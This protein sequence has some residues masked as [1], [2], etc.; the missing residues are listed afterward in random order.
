MEVG[1]LKW[2]KEFHPE[3]LRCLMGRPARLFSF[4]LAV[5]T[6]MLLVLLGGASV[7]RAQD[8]PG[9]WSKPVMISEEIKSW[10]P[11]LATDLAGGVHV[12]WATERAALEKGVG[13]YDTV[14]YCQPTVAG[15]SQSIE[16]A[17]LA[18]GGGSYSTRPAAVVDSQG[19]IHM[20]WHGPN[21][22]Y[23]TSV[24]VM[25]SS[26]ARNW[27]P[28]RR[29]SGSGL[30][31]YVDV[32]QDHQG[33][34]HVVWSESILENKSEDCP[35][36]SDI[37]YR[38]SNDRG[39]TWSAPVD[40]SNTVLGSQKPQIAIG[41][42][43]AVYVA[44]EEGRDLLVGADKASSSMLVASLD[45]G[46]TWEKP[47]TFIF[48]GD[49]PQSIAAGIDGQGK[50]IVVWRQIAGRGIFYQS[51][52]DHG[53]SWSA[54]E[55]IP[56]VSTRSLYNGLD[57]YH[58][59]VDSAGHLHL[60]L[61]GTDPRAV[62]ASAD[63]PNDTMLNSVYHLEWDGVHWSQPTPIF[64][65]R[66]D[67]PEWPRIA[68]V[69]GNQLHVVWFVRD[70]AHVW[71]S[72]KGEYRVW[73]A[74]GSSSAPVETPVAWPAA[75][76]TPESELVKVASLAPVPPPTLDPGL[77]EVS[78]PPGATDSIYTETDDLILLVKSL[79]PAMLVITLAVVVARIRRRG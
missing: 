67:V 2:H 71:Q 4:R 72:D 35:G 58:M 31:Y 34:L 53:Q 43:D 10:F 46:L 54:P 5:C 70:E 9:S 19:T 38:R 21:I 65:V 39:R 11:G 79:L 75:K 16:V 47:T 26:S 40:L 33:V 74:R 50:L 36:C 42:D 18:S 29:I 32:A 45:G 3:Q 7:S 48:P 28:S 20:L 1:P 49:T 15:C 44:W 13:G 8:E 14:A 24:P 23:Y 17:A 62:V 73:Y 56:G 61:V 66:G 68:V 63:Q 76:P 77:A 78:V 59:A 25:Q 41:P 51:S 64:A 37:F 27:S 55:Q 52:T 22:I 12:F 69:N 60:V 30:A 57:G 6:I